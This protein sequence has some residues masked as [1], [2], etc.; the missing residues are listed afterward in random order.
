MDNELND[1]SLEMADIFDD[2]HI[3]DD[4][5]GT[6]LTPTGLMVLIETFEEVDPTLRTSVFGNFLWP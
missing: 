4:T 5:G 2:H 6:Y 1:I 3:I